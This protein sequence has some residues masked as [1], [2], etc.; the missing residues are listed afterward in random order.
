MVLTAPPGSSIDVLGRLI[1]DKLRERLGQPVVP[2][3]RA[4]AGGTVGTNE[5]A[6]A[7]PDGYTIGLSFTG[8]LATAPYLYAKLPYD[9][10]TDLAPIVLVGSAPN[11]LAVNAALPINT[12]ADFLAYVRARPGQLN[13][14]SIGNGSASHLAMELLKV[15]ANLFIVHIP[16]NG[17]P[18]AVQ[19]VAAGEVQAIMSNPTS[20][21][22]LLQAKRIKALAVTSRTRWH[23]M[24]TLPTVA[25]SGFARFEAIAWNGF[26]APAGTPRPIVERLNREIDALLHSPELKPRI[27]AAGWD[28]VG[29]T[30]EAFAAFMQAE[31]ARWQP[32]IRRSG[33]KLD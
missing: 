33:A 9:P 3:N 19:A 21:L 4:Q 18:P 16:F 7:A 26:V 20:L 30:P 1:A 17:A 11:L 13:Y 6:K 32:V 22:P 10:A 23:G 5:V 15:E 27:E 29:G 24:P 25:E 8:P 12:F 2:D 28:P 31:R 14:A